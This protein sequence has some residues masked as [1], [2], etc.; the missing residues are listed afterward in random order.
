MRARRVRPRRRL[1]RP[2]PRQSPPATWAQERVRRRRPSQL[3]P[4]AF[5]GR[6]LKWAHRRRPRGRGR[7][8]RS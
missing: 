6:S 4:A 8:A 2:R 3:L 5:P 1:R 7:C